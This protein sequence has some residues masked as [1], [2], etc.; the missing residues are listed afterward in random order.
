MRKQWL[1]RAT[2]TALAQV[3]GGEVELSHQRSHN[4]LTTSPQ[5]HLIG[6]S[7]ALQ[8][9][10]SPNF[11]SEIRRLDPASTAE[12]ELCYGILDF[13][14]IQ[15]LLID[16]ASVLVTAATSVWEK[17][18]KNNARNKRQRPAG[19]IG[20]PSSMPVHLSVSPGPHH[21]LQLPYKIYLFP[22]KCFFPAV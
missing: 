2:L 12:V 15:G 10:F 8:F 3:Q 9:S 11:G 17:K 7:R 13:H 21:T 1:R 20:S 19:L 22:K 14:Q 16:Q 4:S 5:N 18:L 6:V